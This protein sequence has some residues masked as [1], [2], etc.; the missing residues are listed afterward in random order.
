MNSKLRKKLR[1]KIIYMNA[2]CSLVGLQRRSQKLKIKKNL[3]NFKNSWF[4]FDMNSSTS[5][6]LR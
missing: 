5:Y 3:G 2:D 4:S 1:N 6:I